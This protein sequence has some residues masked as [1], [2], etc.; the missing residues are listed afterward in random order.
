MAEVSRWMCRSICS[1]SRF[2]VFVSISAKIGR[3]PSHCSELVV[4]TKLNGVVM[5]LPVM[6]SA[7]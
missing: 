5:A 7:R 3:M 1:G 6:P 4:A 2:Q